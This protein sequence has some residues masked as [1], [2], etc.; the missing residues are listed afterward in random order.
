[1]S[2]PIGDGRGASN[3]CHA[4]HEHE[5]ATGT[6]CP[7]NEIMVMCQRD[8]AQCHMLVGIFGRQPGYTM[9]DDMILCTAEQSPLFRSTS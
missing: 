8:A 3:E 6:I 2:H 9:H 7:L 1:M 4:H 5:Y